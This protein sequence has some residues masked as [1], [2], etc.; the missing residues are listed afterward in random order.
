MSEKST[1]S[2][3]V[4]NP[5]NI[6][7]VANAIGTVGI[8]YWGYTAIRRLTKSVDELN[9]EVKKITSENNQRNMNMNLIQ[10][11]LNKIGIDL[12][13]ISQMLDGCDIDILPDRLDTLEE[14]AKDKNPDFHPFRR[15]KRSHGGKKVKKVKKVKKYES[16]S[17]ESSEGSSG[18][19]DDLV[20]K[21]RSTSKRG[22]KSSK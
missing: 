21:S 7:V 1:L 10:S 8:G 22:K 15:R 16:S 19:D 12:K 11:N 6:L 5:L 2:S 20:M 13:E 4:E 18:E 9:E 17:D 3:T 14:E